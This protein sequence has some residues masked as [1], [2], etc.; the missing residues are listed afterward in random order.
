VRERRG[1]GARGSAV[2]G[3]G[4]EELAEPRVEGGRE[5]AMASE[6]AAQVRSSSP[7]SARS[8]AAPRRPRHLAPTAAP[9]RPR[10]LAPRRLLRGS[11]R[12]RRLLLRLHRHHRVLRVADSGRRL[13]LFLRPA[14]LCRALLRGGDGGGRDK[15][16]PPRVRRVPGQLLRVHALQGRE[17]L[18]P[19]PPPRTPHRLPRIPRGPHS[20]LCSEVHAL[21][22]GAFT[23]RPPS[24]NP[25]SPVSAGLALTYQLS[26]K[27]DL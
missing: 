26:N 22:A 8:T 13:L 17:A 21:A 25:V 3:G 18:A 2:R 1:G 15:A 7:R 20:R 12:R 5:G 9:R 14:R 24:S 23:P 4:E 16:P 19:V 10:H 27:L 11:R 6:E